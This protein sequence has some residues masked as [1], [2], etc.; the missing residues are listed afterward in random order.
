MDAPTTPKEEQMRPLLLAVATLALAASTTCARAADQEPS[1]H[2]NAQYIEACSCSLFCACYFNT[3]PDKDYCDFDNAI[4]VKSGHY[5]NVKLDGMKI[6][7]SGNLGENFTDHLES[8]V[9]TFEPSASQEQVDAAVKCLTHIY[10]MKVKNV[11][12][13]RAPIVWE[14]RDQ[15]KTAYAK[16]GDGQGEVTLTRVDGPNGGPVVINNLK[17]WGAERNKGFNLYK[18]THHYKGH[19]HDYHFEDANGFTIEIDSGSH[20]TG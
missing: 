14:M 10:P 15:G 9:F 19:G 7:M 5:G 1:W 20:G 4:R 18:S 6:W 12:I 3:K 8:V 13:D 2:F 11:A 16:L 17:Y